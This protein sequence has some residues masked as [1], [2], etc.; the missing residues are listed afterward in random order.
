MTLPMSDLQLGLLG[1]GVLIVGGVY[2]YNKWQ[3]AQL[4]KRL[5]PQRAAPG[6]TSK[7]TSADETGAPPGE[8]SRAPKTTVAAGERPR[9]AE[10][11]EHVMKGPAVDPAIKAAP[12]TVLVDGVDYVIE[13]EAA[14]AVNGEQVRAGIATHLKEVHH[15]VHWDGLDLDLD[16]WTA[17]T[18]RGR[19]ELVRIGL[20]LCNR[21]GPATAEEI[22]A[23]AAGVQS[24]ATAL[25]GV[26]E[27]PDVRQAVADAKALDRFCVDVDVQI[28]FNLTKPDGGTFP[29]T[30]IRTLAEAAGCTLDGDGTYRRRDQDGAELFALGNLDAGGRFRAETMRDLATRGLAVTLD[31]PRSPG[32]PNAFRRFL[33]FARQIAQTLDGVLVDDNRR[34]LSD[35]A[36]AQ[37]GGQLESVHRT[38]TER[39]VAPGSRL[40]LRLFA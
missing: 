28:G 19:Y 9:E 17:G 2:A 31:V 15:P 27:V 23:F 16:D 8:A 35:A 4:E 30:K 18:E 24:L 37:I 6:P 14:E 38:M 25:G 39:G 33:D 32:G 34:P 10:R 40:A 11:V 1:I 12:Q 5:R 26:A 3:E 13:V 22:A 21:G 7:S 29:G 36:F 20:Q